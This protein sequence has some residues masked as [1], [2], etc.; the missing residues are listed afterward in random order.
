MRR[1]RLIWVTLVTLVW[2][3]A[4]AC[5]GPAQTGKGGQT[6]ADDAPP[7]GKS[8]EDYLASD[9]PTRPADTREADQMVLHMIDIGQGLAVLFE[10]PCGAVLID[11]GG[12]LNESFDS[13]D[14][15]RTFLKEFFQRRPD[16]DNTLSALVLTHPH[17]DHTRGVEVV[18]EEAAITNVVT[19]GQKNDDLGGHPQLMLHSWVKAENKKRAKKHKT[20]IGFIELDTSMIP[21]NGLT[22]DIIDPVAGCE[23][24]KVDPEITALWGRVDSDHYSDNANDHSVV[25]RINYGKSS[26]LLSGDLELEGLDHLGRKYQANPGVLDVDVYVVGHHG[27]KNA[28]APHLMKAMT[29]KIALISAG[30]Y[31]RN[32]DWTARRYGHPNI[33]AVNKLIDPNFGVS[34]YRDSVEVWMGISGAW[35]KERKEVFKRMSINRAV[36]STG[37]DGAIDV[38]MYAN[39]WLEVQ[40]AGRN[41]VSAE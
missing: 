26:V 35:K 20:P 5:S 3:A 16:L 33:K 41:K 9:R 21:N 28:T 22:N 24:S 34:W 19:N 23:A 38:K 14:S 32:H 4:P 12:E 39:G 25:L 6:P 2:A 30:P 17:I 7:R 27:S 11:T 13:R 1:S 18:L 40:T 10:F 29:P 8:F 36:Y 15:L 37:W 31:G